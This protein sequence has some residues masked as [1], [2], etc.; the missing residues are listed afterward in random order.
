MSDILSPTDSLKYQDSIKL[1]TQHSP[2]FINRKSV[3]KTEVALTLHISSKF[4]RSIEQ[5]P[6]DTGLTFVNICNTQFSFMQ[7]KQCDRLESRLRTLCSEITHV[8][9]HKYKGGRK[10]QEFND[11]FHNLAVFKNELTDVSLSFTETFGQ[12]PIKVDCKSESGLKVSFKL[13]EN[14]EP[15]YSSEKIEAEDKEA[16]KQI[17]FLLDKFCISDA[18]FHELSMLVDDM[19]RKYMI[20]Q[21]RDDINKI[22]HIERLPESFQTTFEDSMTES[23]NISPR[24][25]LKKKK[26]NQI[27]FLQRNT[28]SINKAIQTENEDVKKILSSEKPYA[29]YERER[30]LYFISKAKHK[31]KHDC[32][33]SAGSNVNWSALARKFDVKTIKNQVPTNIGQVLMMFAKSKGI[34]VYQFN[35]QSRKIPLHEI[36]TN[37][38]ERI[39]KAGILRLNQDSY[40][41]EMD[42]EKII[43]RLKELNEDD[44]EG[45]TEF[46]RNKL[47]TIETTRQIK[48]WH[49]HSC[50][51]NHTYINFMIN[52]VY[53]RANFLTDEEFQK[54]NP[55]L[56]RIDCQKIVEKPQLY[57]LGQSGTIV[58]HEC[59]HIINKGRLGY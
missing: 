32:K 41:N 16:L 46:L 40:Y 25:F 56:S 43:N 44:T 31:R 35:T 37:E 13:G 49:D 14:N 26:K 38:N 55:T 12:K 53:D 15:K 36:L 11:K 45:N 3:D 58:K 8:Y 47:K 57:I 7:L 18:A 4:L 42:K 34:N 2:C 23:L 19:P 6:I 17:L 1:S 22:Y 24:K 29:Q 30:K 10:R 21:C 5:C 28:R 33:I 20:V 51:L 39:E 48:V 9:M 27:K 54:H 50:I 52:Y 59:E